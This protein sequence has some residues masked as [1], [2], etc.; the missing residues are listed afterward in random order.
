MKKYTVL[1]SRT[2]EKLLSKVPGKILAT[3]NE[4]ID[5]LSIEPRPY[6]SQQLTGHKGL[7]KIRVGE[8]RIIYTIKH[9]LLQVL[10][11]DIEHRSKVYR[12]L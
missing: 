6:Y 12:N 7:F 3:I 8:Y 1:I 11:I 5:E 9:D 2:A 4:R 10:V